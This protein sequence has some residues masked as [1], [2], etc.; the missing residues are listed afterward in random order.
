MAGQRSSDWRSGRRRAEISFVRQSVAFPELFQAP[1]RSR[2]KRL[3][4]VSPEIVW[5]DCVHQVDK[6]LRGTLSPD[7]L[8]PKPSSDGGRECHRR[9]PLDF[10]VHAG[11]VNPNELLAF[12]PVGT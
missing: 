12:D 5:W 4:K 10:R 3:L 8:V 6:R 2:L 11:P 1:P 9:W 7:L